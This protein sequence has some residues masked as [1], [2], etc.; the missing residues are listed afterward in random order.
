MRVPREPV[1]G[2]DRDEAAIQ[3]TSSPSRPIRTRSTSS[4]STCQHVRVLGLG[5]RTVFDG[6]CGG[7][8]DHAGDRRREFRAMLAASA[9][10]TNTFAPLRPRAI[11]RGCMDCSRSGI[12]ISS[13]PQT[14]AVLPYKQYLKRFPAYLQQLIMESNGKRAPLDG[15]AVDCQTATDRWGQPGTNGQHAFYQLLH[16]GTSLVASDFIGFSRTTVRSVN[17]TI[18]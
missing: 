12:S 14:I 4:A 17:S 13:A 1:P 11:C 16:Q 18:C 7:A 6:L 8:V 9:R 10:W 2:G 3:G 15:A 5:R